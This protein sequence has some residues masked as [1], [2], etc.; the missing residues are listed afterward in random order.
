ML[1][2]RRCAKGE[3]DKK[4]QRGGES[5]E[6]D[7]ENNRNFYEVRFQLGKIKGNEG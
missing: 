4:G 1:N 7:G 2:T 3:G 6:D 5:K